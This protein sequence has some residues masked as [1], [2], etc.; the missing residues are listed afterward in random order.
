MG[1][2]DDLSNLKGRP[3]WWEMLK[4][5]S[6][7]LDLHRRWGSMESLNLYREQSGAHLRVLP[8]VSSLSKLSIQVYYID[9]LR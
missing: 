4:I 2:E 3:D 1:V 9:S 8:T 7:G 6:W 5:K